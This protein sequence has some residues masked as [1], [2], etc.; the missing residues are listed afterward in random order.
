MRTAS[1][2]SERPSLSARC[3]RAAHEL[4]G[5]AI[6]PSPAGAS[7]ESRSMK[8]GVQQQRDLKS[9][10]ALRSRCPIGVI[11]MAEIRTLLRRQL[12]C[13]RRSNR[14]AVE[15]WCARVADSDKERES[16]Q[17]KEVYGQQS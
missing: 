4:D 3:R 11:T 6:A 2:R 8:Y 10:A 9:V 12:Y 7:D 1:L 16:A 5:A 17:R 13:G 14:F 15:N